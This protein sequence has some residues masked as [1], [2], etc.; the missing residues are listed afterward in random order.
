MGMAMAM[1]WH[2]MASQRLPELEAGAFKAPLVFCCVEA[3]MPTCMF[4][5]IRP[6]LSHLPQA[7]NMVQPGKR[8]LTL[9]SLLMPITACHFLPQASNM[10]RPGDASMAAP[11]TAKQSSVMPCLDILKQG[12][13][14]LVRLWLPWIMWRA[15]WPEDWAF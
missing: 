5:L 6:A 4:C 2:G 8:H 3:R 12:R 13:C 7:S 10:V 1:A 9:S 15:W 11:F 14:T